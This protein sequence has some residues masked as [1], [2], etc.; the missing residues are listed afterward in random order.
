[1]S[2]SLTSSFGNFV[3]GLS[4]IVW[5]ILNSILAVFQAIIAL[6]EN[7]LSGVFHLFNAILGFFVNLFEGAAGFVAGMSFLPFW[8]TSE[9]CSILMSFSRKFPRCPRIGRC[10]LVVHFYPEWT[11]SQEASQEEGIDD[12]R[13]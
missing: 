2:T 5:N 1:M 12:V 7:I 9:V 10:L 3:K 6:A 8:F 11:E 4:G 13:L